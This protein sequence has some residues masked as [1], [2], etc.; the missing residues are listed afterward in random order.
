MSRYAVRWNRCGFLL[1]VTFLGASLA[2]AQV[3]TGSIAGTVT[4]ASGAVLSGAKVTMTNEATGA[5][6]STVSGADGVYNFSPVRIGNYKLDVSASGFKTAVQSHV[7]VDVSARVLQNFQLQPGAVSETVEV[8]SSAP[9]LQS[10]DASVG[11]VVDQRSVNNLPLNGR[12]FTFLAQLAAG[13]NTPQSDTRGNASSGAF[14]ANGNRPAQNNYML[15]GVDNNSDTVDF[16]NGTNFVVL[17]PVDAIQEF[18]V[19]TSD[20][21]AEY[22]RSG[23][24]VLNATIKSGT[25]SF[26]G[27]VWEFLRNDKLDAADWFS[28]NNG[29]PKGEL[30][31]NQFGASI[32]GPIFKNKLFFFGDYEGLRVV[33]GTVST[34]TVP[35]LAERNSGY[36]NLADI[37]T[38]Q[39]GTL[40]ADAVGR[41]VPLGTVLDPAT[42]RS[43]VAGTVDPV[44]GRVATTTGFVRDPFGTCSPS[45]ADRKS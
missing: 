17:P 25:N 35:T 9:V 44:S 21:S 41:Q 14:T 42:T 22:G 6:L 5:S 33:Q 18:K 28:N 37:I 39:G 27:A 38:G 2:W 7:V 23:G 29:T 34:A 32:G 13:V 45:T 12:N 15:D 31:F 26:H 24:A 40:R 10:Q 4:D 30:R 1:L 19:E 43:V 3:D 11:Q 8:T 20:F 36:S 16:L